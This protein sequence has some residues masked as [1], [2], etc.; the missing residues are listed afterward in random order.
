MEYLKS[1]FGD[2][3][4]TFAE[5]EAALKDNKEIKLANLASGQYVDK[6]KFDKAELK[7]GDLQTQLT[8]ANDT[9][10]GFK[11]LDPDG[12][13]KSVKDWEKKYQDDTNALNLKLTEQTKNSKIEF[14]LLTA[15]AK[16]TKAARALLDESKIS[17]DGENLLGLNEQL[18]TLKKDAAYLFEGE[19]PNNPPPPA[20]GS[21]PKN[22]NDEVAKWIA[23]A[24]LPPQKTN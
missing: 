10:K 2:K 15:K 12:L 24:G 8:A 14:A 17:L 5:L 13:K 16:N 4:L 19:K 9:I 18:E 23:E 1:V 11:D 6:D 22:T 20:G 21:D 3:A 7:A